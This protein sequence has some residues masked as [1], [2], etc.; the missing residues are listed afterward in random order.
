MSLP[1]LAIFDG[2]GF[3]EMLLVAF[4]SVLVFGGRL[5][6]VM[7][8]LGRTYA[9]FRQS[10]SDI[11]RPIRDEIKAATSYLPN[12]TPPPALPPPI[13]PAL[14]PGQE[15]VAAQAY[16]AEAAPG[17]TA[18]RA[19]LPAP[20]PEAPAWAAPW[21]GPPTRAPE[22]PPRPPPDDSDEARLV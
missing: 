10:L 19:P 4:I 21:P 7:R 13:P 11:S 22:P 20:R 5:P 3:S 12:V 14:G 1:A 8:N 18:P 9:K 17:G 15:P 6:E 16:D 2:I